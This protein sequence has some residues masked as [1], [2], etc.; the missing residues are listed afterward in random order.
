MLPVGHIIGQHDIFFH[1]NADDTQL[2]LSFNPKDLSSL[3]ILHNCL[4]DIRGWIAQ[5]LQL[6]TK[7]EIQI[8]GPD[9]SLSS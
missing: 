1:F 4:L 9:P 2:Y 5:N 7:T 8:M 6:K 3:S